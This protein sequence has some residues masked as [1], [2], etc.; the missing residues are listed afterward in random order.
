MDVEELRMQDFLE[1][2]ESLRGVL[3]IEEKLGAESGTTYR[4]EF[5]A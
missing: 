3:R 5:L 1:T 4:P 2:D